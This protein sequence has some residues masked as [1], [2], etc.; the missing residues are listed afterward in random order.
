MIFY[1]RALSYLLETEND[2]V[3]GSSVGPQVIPLQG[4]LCSA[5]CRCF[6]EIHQ[7]FSLLHLPPPYPHLLPDLVQ[8]LASSYREMWLLQSFAVL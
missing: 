6:P 7:S 5:C 3:S 4:H 2:E 8:V 1:F